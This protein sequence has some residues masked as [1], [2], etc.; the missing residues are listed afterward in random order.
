MKI[1]SLLRATVALAVVLGLVQFA[2]AGC[3][4]CNF[5]VISINAQCHTVTGTACEAGICTTACSPCDIQPP[6]PQKK[7]DPPVVK[8]K[9]KTPEKK[10]TTAPE[11]TKKTKRI[12]TV[13]G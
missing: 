6:E 4:R 9:V 1:S 3:G 12:K 10:K 13:E 7:T 8:E 2:E 5:G 11:E